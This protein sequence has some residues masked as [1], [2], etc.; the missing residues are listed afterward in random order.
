M[1]PAPTPTTYLQQPTDLERLVTWLAAIAAR[2]PEA[3]RLKQLFM[4]TFSSERM[5]IEQ[6]NEATRQTSAKVG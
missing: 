3:T 2:H 4:A 5:A 1:Q 6:A